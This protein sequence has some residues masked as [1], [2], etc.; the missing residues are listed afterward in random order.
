VGLLSVSWQGTFLRSSNLQGGVRITRVGGGRG[1]G[2]EWQPAV[3][4]VWRGVAC[5][6]SPP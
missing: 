5:R 1:A 6:A 2:G 3:A 4:A